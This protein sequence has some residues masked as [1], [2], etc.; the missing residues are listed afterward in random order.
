[1]AAGK[2]RLA[3]PIGQHPLQRLR[4]ESASPGHVGG[5]PPLSLLR[6][7]NPRVGADEDGPGPGSRTR[8]EGMEGETGTE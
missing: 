6:I 4:D 8:E 7:D 1:M 2:H 5:Q 3:I